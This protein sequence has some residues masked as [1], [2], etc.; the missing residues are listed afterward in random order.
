MRCCGC[1]ATCSP[2]S[3]ALLYQ[4]L[5][6]IAVLTMVIGVLGAAYHWDMRRILAFHIVSQIG[7]MLL[8]HRPGR[9]AAG[10]AGGDVLHVAQHGGEGRR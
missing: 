3:P 8:R 9:H 10:S 5:G 2:D 7:Y 1:S 6:W 4:A